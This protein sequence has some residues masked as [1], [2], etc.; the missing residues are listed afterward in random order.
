[1]KEE[2]E[3]EKPQETLKGDREHCASLARAVATVFPDSRKA[4]FR[5]NRR[6]V[7]HVPLRYCS[8]C[9]TTKMKTE[10]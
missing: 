5:E 3:E 4:K 10:Q 7:L 1:S 6:G 2:E 9:S 8:G